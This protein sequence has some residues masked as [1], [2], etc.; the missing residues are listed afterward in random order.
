M[1]NARV[2]GT[3]RSDIMQRLYIDREIPQEDALRWPHGPIGQ[4]K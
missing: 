3:K 2:Q 1:V 4:E